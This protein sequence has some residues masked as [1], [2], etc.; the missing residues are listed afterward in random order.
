PLQDLTMPQTTLYNSLYGPTA[1]PLT[2]SVIVVGAVLS[3]PVQSKSS[4]AS[5]CPNTPDAKFHN[6]SMHQN[7]AHL[8][9]PGFVISFFQLLYLV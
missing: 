9:A 6:L 7:A 5:S 8:Y 4:C 2:L 3:W 1:M